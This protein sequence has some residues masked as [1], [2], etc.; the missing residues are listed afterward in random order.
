MPRQCSVWW[1]GVV[2]CSVVGW[3]AGQ[4][5][6]GGG[7]GASRAPVPGEDWW[8]RTATRTD[9][10]VAALAAGLLATGE[11]SPVSCPGPGHP[12]PSPHAPHAPVVPPHPPPSDLALSLPPLHGWHRC[13]C[14]TAL[15][16]SPSSPSFP[17]LPFHGSKICLKIILKSANRCIAFPWSR[18]SSGSIDFFSF[19]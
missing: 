12:H 4:A 13:T 3:R 7:R 1:C 8:C 17:H 2:Q 19:F 6:G 5:Q 18:F 11:W 9:M 15:P 14:A 16:R 10:L